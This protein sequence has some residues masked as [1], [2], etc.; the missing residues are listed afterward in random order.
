[1]ERENSDGPMVQPTMD[2][3]Q[4]TIFKEKVCIFGL[5]DES[6]K[7]NGKITK[8]MVKVYY[9]GLMAKSTKVTFRT[10]IDKD[11]VYLPGPMVT[12]TMVNGW[13]A[14]STAKE[15]SYIRGRPSKVNG[16]KEKELDG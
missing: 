8:C 2:S 11:T 5:M 1:M 14:N 15:P 9:N 6:M 10:T 3:S 13:M 12:N 16:K 7:V 4:T